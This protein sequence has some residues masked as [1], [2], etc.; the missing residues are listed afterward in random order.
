MDSISGDIER[1]HQIIENLDSV[2]LGTRKD[3]GPLVIFSRD[4]ISVVLENGRTVN[5]VPV[6]KSVLNEYWNVV[7]RAKK[8]AVK[9]E[10]KSNC[11]A[12]SAFDIR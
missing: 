11:S 4:L 1:A 5:F 12:N 6:Y 3:T 2:D 9:M 10:S 8:G 7:D